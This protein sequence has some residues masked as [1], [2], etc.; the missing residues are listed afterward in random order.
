M[1][2][3][4]WFATV[5]A[6]VLGWCVGLAVGLSIYLVGEWTCPRQ[7]VVSESCFAPWSRGIFVTATVL[8]AAVAA[9]LVVALP[10]LVAPSHKQL[11]ATLAFVGG[12]L[13]AGYSFLEAQDVSGAPAIAAVVAGAGSLWHVSRRVSGS[14]N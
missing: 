1:V 3:L 11:A 10:A 5:L 14:S 8:G 9:A 6:I 13:F 4:R 7:Y 2:A 12:C